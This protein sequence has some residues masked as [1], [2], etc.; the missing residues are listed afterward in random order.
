MGDVDL[1]DSAVA[2]DG[3]GVPVI[4]M[5]LFAIARAFVRLVHRDLECPRRAASL[6]RICVA[7]ATHPSMVA[8]DGRFETRM[9]NHFKLGLVVKGGA[10]G[11]CAAAISRRGLGIAPNAVG[12][13]LKID[14]GAKRAAEVAMA[15]LI[16]RFAQRGHGSA[17]VL[18]A[19]LN[20]PLVNTT[21]AR[22][23]RIRCAP[24]WPD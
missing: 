9:M 14:D 18:D 16:E 3:C 23:G 5:P 4:A 11:V 19:Y 6:S 10:E 15:N 7:M 2:I 13:A 12:I 22:V 20:Q 24:G 17:L 21:G 8:G 1:R